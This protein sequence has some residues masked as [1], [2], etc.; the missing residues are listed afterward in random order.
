MITDLS[1]A[2]LQRLSRPQ[3]LPLAVGMKIIG[4][5]KTLMV[6]EYEYEAG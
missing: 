6:G 2:N 4:A 1:E 3:P 5:A